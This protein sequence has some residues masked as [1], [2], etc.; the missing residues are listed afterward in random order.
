MLKV[1]PMFYILYDRML[2]RLNLNCDFIAFVCHMSQDECNVKV[3]HSVRHVISA[4][5]VRGRRSL[6][7]CVTQPARTNTTAP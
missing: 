6:A 7:P 3:R 4:R 2:E 5:N 1:N